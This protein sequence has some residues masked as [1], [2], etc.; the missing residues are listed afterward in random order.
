MKKIV[1]GTALMAVIASTAVAKF[2]GAYVQ[3][4]AAYTWTTTSL[5]S[6]LDLDK[7]KYNLNG[8]GGLATA[9]Y[10]DNCGSVYLGGEIY[11]GA[12]SAN[13]TKTDKGV[14]PGTG[15]AVVMTTKVSRQWNAGIAGRIGGHIDNNILAFFRLG[16]DYAQY[17]I[18]SNATVAGVNRLSLKKNAPV[19]SLV[20]GIGLDMKISHNVYATVAADYSFAINASV[21]SAFKN[22]TKYTKK[23]Q[24]TTLRLGVGYQF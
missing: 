7:I 22:Y 2:E 21:P 17:Q 19:W 23:P 12:F 18:S 11:A 14:Q 10:G 5:E 9:G 20:P 4:E 3:G 15:S 8:F 1:L 16:L 24:S 6:F 13:Q